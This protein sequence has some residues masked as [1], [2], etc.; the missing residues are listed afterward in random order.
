[1]KHRLNHKA[2]QKSEQDQVAQEQ[3]KS[4]PLRFDSPEEAL[5]YDA[6]NIV[7]PPRL[8]GRIARDAAMEQQNSQKNK[9]PWWRKLLGGQS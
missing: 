3:V 9:T 6:A 8:G 2:E 4:A 7:V 1:M 5:R